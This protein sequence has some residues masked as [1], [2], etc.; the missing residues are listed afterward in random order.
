VSPAASTSHHGHGV[1]PRHL[2]LYHDSE[3]RSLLSAAGIVAE[4]FLEYQKN[5]F[6]I[7]HRPLAEDRN[8]V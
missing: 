6:V 8:M 3:S 1:K 2:E 5:I 4:S 7:F